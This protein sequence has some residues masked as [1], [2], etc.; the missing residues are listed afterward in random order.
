MPVAYKGVVAPTN[1]PRLPIAPTEYNQ[2]FVDQLINV[3]R[4]YFGTIDNFTQ[5]ITSGS[6][7]S[8]LHFPYGAFQSTVTQTATANTAT[9]LTFNQTDFSNDVTLV[10]GSKIHVASPGIYNLQFSVQVA[11]S[12]TADQDVS[13]WLRQGNDG[14][15]STDIVGST[16]L[17]SVPSKHGST[18]GHG[19]NGWNYYLSMAADD[20]IQIYWST[21]NTSVTIDAYA[22]GAGP[23]R[24]STASA[25]ATLSFVSAL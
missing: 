9:L 24:P 2:R 16:G 11:N 1:S 3:L 10:S 13:I 5:V 7:A 21:T 17:V 14:G 20:Y 4:L 15:T 19:I 18:P 22:A 12:D 25:V 8:A 6:G 23:T